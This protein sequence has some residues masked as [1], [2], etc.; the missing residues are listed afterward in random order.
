MD[1]RERQRS[2]RWSTLICAERAVAPSGVVAVVR[3]PR[4]EQ[5]WPAIGAARAARSA[6]RC[7]RPSSIR[8]AS[9]TGLASE[10]SLQGRQIRGQV[11]N[12]RRPCISASRST[13]PCSG[14]VTCTLGVLPLRSHVSARAGVVADRHV[15][16]G[17]ADEHAG[18]GFAGRQRDRRACARSAADRASP[19][20]RPPPRSCR[21]RS[22][23]GGV[24]PSCRAPMPF[25]SP[26]GEWQRAA[27]AGAVEIR[28]AGR[29]VAGHHV[30]QLVVRSARRRR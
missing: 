14:S 18:H 4:V 10:R 6:G 3:R 27:A 12:V 23:P 16:V 9:S 28:L 20:P 19:R 2:S 26:A 24:G 8:S 15:E 7:I 30:L 5:S 25:K 29:G 13:C 21:R 1:P 22:A 11:V 17:Q